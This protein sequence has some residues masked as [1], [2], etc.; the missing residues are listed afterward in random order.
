MLVQTRRCAAAGVDD[1]RL[2]MLPGLDVH[3]VRSTTVTS[4]KGLDHKQAAQQCRSTA[5]VWQAAPKHCPALCPCA[6][7][8][9]L[10]LSA[11]LG[12]LQ[13][14]TAC[15]TVLHYLPWPEQQATPHDN[16]GKPLT[17]DSNACRFGGTT[18]ASC[19]LR[20]SRLT[21]RSRLTATRRSRLTRSRLTATHADS[22]APPQ[23]AALCGAHVR[24]HPLPLLCPPRLLGRAGVETASR[25]SLR[26]ERDG[27]GRRRAAGRLG[28]WHRLWLG[29]PLSVHPQQ[30]GCP[31]ATT[32]MGRNHAAVEVPDN[33]AMH[34]LTDNLSTLPLASALAGPSSR[35]ASSTGDRL[36]LFRSSLPNTSG[37]SVP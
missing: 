5:T 35:C 17:A 2:R 37:A 10:A 25:W 15:Q 18:A 14:F 16:G 20:R 27:G 31:L 13:V 30:V 12:A 4:T 26:S 33:L 9:R 21:P 23:Q 29:P 36:R 1:A 8:G 7:P 6:A 24:Q 19:T 11:V 32:D 34:S 3:R 22:V 28:L